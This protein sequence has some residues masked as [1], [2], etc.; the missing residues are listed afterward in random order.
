MET[1]Q[2]VK[3][4]YLAGQGVRGHG[5]PAYR[6]ALVHRMDEA[7]ESVLHILKAVYPG[8]S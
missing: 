7:I 3:A 1:A 2:N 5:G 4:D 6:R 8:V